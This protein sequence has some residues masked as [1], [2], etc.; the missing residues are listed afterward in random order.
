MAGGASRSE[1]APSGAGRSLRRWLAPKPFTS[2][3]SAGCPRRSGTGSAPVA[4]PGTPSSR[5][6]SRRD[7]VDREGADSRA[8][9]RGRR[10]RAARPGIRDPPWRACKPASASSTGC[11]AAGSSPAR[12][13]CSA[14]RRASASPRSP[15]WRSAT[16]PAPGT[17]TLYVSG[18]ESA[19]QVRLRAERL[20]PARARGADA[21]RDRP[22]RGARRHRLRTPRACA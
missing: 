20:S 16:S 8:W 22:R 19:E 3:R 10:A 14:A 13:C 2:A 1:P 5:S 4:V 11:S 18:E 12:S 15:T 7:V 17:R 6:G 21:R 9:A